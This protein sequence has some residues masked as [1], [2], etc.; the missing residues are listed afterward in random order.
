MRTP[1]HEQISAKLTELKDIQDNG[2]MG[3]FAACRVKRLM[4]EIEALEAKQRKAIALAEENLK[5]LGWN[6]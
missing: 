6:L 5:R 4:D 2:H 3:M 1:L